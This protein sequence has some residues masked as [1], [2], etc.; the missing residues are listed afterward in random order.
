MT[1][2]YNGN[3]QCGWYFS[4]VIGKLSLSLSCFCFPPIWLHSHPSGITKATSSFRL[5]IYFLS[6]PNGKTCFF[7][8]SFNKNHR[9]ESLVLNGLA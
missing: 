4:K 2:D 7:S 6:N 3:F 8:K 5:I 9:I 1:H